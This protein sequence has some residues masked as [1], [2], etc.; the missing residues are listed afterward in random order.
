MRGAINQQNHVIA[1]V[2]YN[3][4]LSVIDQSSNV[5]PVFVECLE[6]LSDSISEHLIKRTN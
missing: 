4:K 1:S 5:L 3:D 6:M 2:Q